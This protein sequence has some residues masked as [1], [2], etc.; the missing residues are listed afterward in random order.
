M[1]QAH[2][3]CPD[4]YFVGAGHYAAANAVLDGMAAVTQAAGEPCS[5]LQFGPFSE[6]GMAAQHSQQLAALGL[7]GL[8]PDQVSPHKFPLFSSAIL[9][10]FCK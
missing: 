9:A 1:W 2:T 8:S 6:T 5:A 10:S 7:P 3:S 4:F